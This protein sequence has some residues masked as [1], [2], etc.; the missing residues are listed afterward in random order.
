MQA[1]KGYR[2]NWSNQVWTR[3]SIVQMDEYTDTQL[4]DL[5]LSFSLKSQVYLLSPVSD[6]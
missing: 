1:D 5:Q 6:H 3:I 2:H 4:V